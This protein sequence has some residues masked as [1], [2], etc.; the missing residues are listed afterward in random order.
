MGGHQLSQPVDPVDDAVGAGVGAFTA[1]TGREL[2][3]P[4]HYQ[5]NYR[6]YQYA[7]IAPHCGDSVLEVGAGAG[8]FSAQFTGRS[9]VVVTDVDPEA[10]AS[11]AERF[12]GRPEVTAHQLDAA[13][14]TPALAERYAARQGAV[15]SVLAINVLEHIEDHVTALESMA[16]LVRPGGTVVLWVPAYM[17]L[18]GDFD[19][20]VGHVRRYAPATLGAAAQQAHL[21]VRV[22][23][24]VN[25]LGG[26]A[27]W[28]AVRKGGT[29]SPKPSLVR[30]YDAVVVPATR[31]VDRF[32]VP[33]GQSVLGVFTRPA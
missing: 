5:R 18:Y 31:I 13:R 28:A 9:R 23:R 26:I 27:W 19:R 8:D 17:A 2:A 6:R 32:R 25:L 1:A 24:P 15:D 16:R 11:M 21:G 10:V 14:L 33:F 3:R 7:L 20:S 29:G 30:A 12:A 22:C 4:D